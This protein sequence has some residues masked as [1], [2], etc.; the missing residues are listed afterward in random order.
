MNV[1]IVGNV[2]NPG[3]YTLSGGSSALSLI[4]AAGGIDESAHAD[5]FSIKGMAK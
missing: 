4:N 3:M 2:R 5:Q 1:M